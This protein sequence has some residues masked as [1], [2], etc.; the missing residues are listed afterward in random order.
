VILS[1]VENGMS[2]YQLFQ[3][4]LSVAISFE[5]V[6]SLRKMMNYCS[7][8]ITSQGVV[9]DYDISIGSIKI[10]NSTDVPHIIGDIP[11]GISNLSYDS[12]CDF[13]QS[14]NLSKF[15]ILKVL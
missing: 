10:I 14:I 2:L 1:T 13:V 15:S 4:I 9:F 6:F 3:K 8:D 7:V 12:N 11:D 5:T